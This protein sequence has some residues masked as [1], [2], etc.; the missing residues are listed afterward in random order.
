MASEKL[1][2]M[3]LAVAMLAVVLG[4]AGYI[5]VFWHN[6]QGCQQL[7]AAAAKN[8]KPMSCTEIKAAAKAQGR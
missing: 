4:V 2:K 8:G 5:L 6:Y 7:E 1:V 3:G